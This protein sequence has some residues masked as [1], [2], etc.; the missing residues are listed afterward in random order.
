LQRKYYETKQGK[1]IYLRDT[2]PI[3]FDIGLLIKKINKINPFYLKMVKKFIFVK[4]ERL[5]DK[6]AQHKNGT[7]F[8]SNEIYDIDRCFSSILREISHIF[9]NKNQKQIEKNIKDDFFSK[10]VNFYYDTVINTNKVPL[11]DFLYE[12]KNSNFESFVRKIEKDELEKATKRYFL[13]KDSIF[14]IKD[15]FTD[16]FI[17]FHQKKKTKLK[18][19]HKKV[20]KIIQ[21][22]PPQEKL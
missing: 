8:V 11:C 2:A 17:G 9:Y 13:N 1:P 4:Q 18:T 7:I 21:H 14:S 19:D 6:K 15:Y 12:E 10:K 22:T 16:C 3:N 5:F 20:Y